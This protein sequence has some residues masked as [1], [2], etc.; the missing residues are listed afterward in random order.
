MLGLCKP[1]TKDKGW[2]FF[3]LKRYYLGVNNVDNISSIDESKLQSYVYT[4]E[5]RK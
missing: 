4:G 2:N 3:R 1:H 5:T